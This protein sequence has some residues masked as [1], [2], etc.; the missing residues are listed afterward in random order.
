MSLHISRFDSTVRGMTSSTVLELPR[1]R[2]PDPVDAPTLRWGILGPGWIAE[3]FVESLQRNTAQE[4]TAVASRG[5]TRAQAFADN[6]GIGRAHGS[7]DALL[8]SEDVDV[9]YVATPH[10]AHFDCAIAALDHG[11]HVVVEK[12]LALNAAQGRAIQERT[13]A[14]GLFCMEAMWTS[15]LPKFD[16]I[17]Q[18]LEAGLLGTI[19]TVLADHGERFET[20]HRIYDPALAGG[21]LLDLGTYPVSLAYRV[22]GVPTAVAALGEPANDMVNGQISAVLSWAGIAQ[23]S[24]NTTILA[25]T[26]NTASICGDKGMIVLDSTFYRP[27]AF[28]VRLGDGRSARY[29][30]P[31]DGYVGGL[32]FEAA[33]AARRITAGDIESPV[34]P[35][36]AAIATLDIL[37]EIRRQVGITFP[38]EG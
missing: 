38:G 19:R 31:V 34:H 29:D 26:P 30:D 13:A 36:D 15:F 12:P 11:K 22:L 23:A 37:D 1:T 2:V 20:D 9:V 5:L 24:L 27:G 33:E 7:Y 28:T 32:A 16:V 10:T 25:D 4:V 35:L 3:R 6:W 8:A 21:P 17:D 14:L 18:I